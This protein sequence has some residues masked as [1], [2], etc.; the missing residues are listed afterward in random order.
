MAIW[1]NW[2]KIKVSKAAKI[3][4]KIHLKKHISLHLKDY[5]NSTFVCWKTKSRST[6]YSSK[7]KK[8]QFVWIHLL[9]ENHLNDEFYWPSVF[10]YEFK[11]QSNF[12]LQI[13]KSTAVSHILKTLMNLT[14][15][16]IEILYL[17]RH[18]GK[19][20]RAAKAFRYSFQRTSRDLYWQV[21][22]FHFLNWVQI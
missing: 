5:S 7:R 9:V 1:R 4:C 11:I 14:F 22:Y 12:T 3:F 20:F 13:S 16:I 18:E 19:A 2:L 10:Y 17:F 21:Q 6:F 8:C 15:K